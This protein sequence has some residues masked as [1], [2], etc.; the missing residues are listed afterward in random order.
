MLD[1]TGNL[2]SVQKTIPKEKIFDADT[3]EHF[4]VSD[5]QWCLSVKPGIRNV[6]PY[7]EGR[8]RLEE[9]EAL[10]VEVNSLPEKTG[11]K[12]LLGQIHAK[13]IA[14]INYFMR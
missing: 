6:T 14:C 5:V 9:I 11:Y 8:V 2:A 10:I 3:I 1:F 4:L 13:M 12:T 7:I